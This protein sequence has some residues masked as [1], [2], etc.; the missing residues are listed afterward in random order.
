M[1]FRIVWGEDKG[2]SD[3]YRQNIQQVNNEPVFYDQDAEI[4]VQKP[5]ANK[6]TDALKAEISEIVDRYALQYGSSSEEIMITLKCE[7]GYRHEGVYGDSGLAYGIAQ[8]H[9]ATFNSFKKTA[10]MPELEYKDRTDQIQLMAWAF[11]KGLK[12]HWTCATKNGIL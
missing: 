8:F 2:L 4:T 7:S 11:S 3:V 1:D 12:R 6:T 10:G 9:E 5:S